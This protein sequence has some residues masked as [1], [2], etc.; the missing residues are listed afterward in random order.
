MD[1]KF[2]TYKQINNFMR[3]YSYNQ[4]N[5]TCTKI[6][7]YGK[8]GH[9]KR[10]SGGDRVVYACTDSECDFTA[11]WRRKKQSN[12]FFSLVK[13]NPHNTMCNSRPI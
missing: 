13:H 6:I 3:D 7:D 8:D 1:G 4:N 12:G 11:F 2:N 9:P 5:S 10:A